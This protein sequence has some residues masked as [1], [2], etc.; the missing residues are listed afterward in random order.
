MSLF[1]IKNL[2]KNYDK[3]QVIQDLSLTLLPQQVTAI[4]GPSGS[5]KS[6][7]L[8]TLNLLED[9]QAG[10]IEYQ[11]QEIHADTFNKNIYRAEVGM[12][13]Q[14]F[15]LFN[16]LT[17]LENCNLAQQKV[18]KR[19]KKEATAISLSMLDKVGLKNYAEQSVTLLSGGQKQRVAI[20]RALCMNPQVLLLD[21]PTSALD[22]QMVD[23][24]LEVIKELSTTQKIT[25]IIVTHEMRFA[26]EISDR[27]IFMMDGKIIEDSDSKTFFS[28][29]RTLEG[30]KFI[31]KYL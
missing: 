10:S 19:S 3:H 11:G 18:L 22:P 4:I 30:Q 28:Q 12:I 2:S 1:E 21:E 15:N 13:F 17:V 14:Q 8:R 5:G 24:V 9:I 26:K 27:V 20:A 29:P 7:L 16:H 6:T 23:E 31:T 25:M